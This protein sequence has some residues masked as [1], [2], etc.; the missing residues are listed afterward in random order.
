M[1]KTITI[2]RHLLFQFLPELVKQKKHIK[3]VSTESNTPTT[4]LACCHAQEG[5]T[6]SLVKKKQN[7]QCLPYVTLLCTVLVSMQ[8][9]NYIVIYYIIFIVFHY[10]YYV[11]FMPVLPIKLFMLLLV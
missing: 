8:V 6:F 7:K 5:M 4:T 3:V 1:L 2:Q 11:F 10:Y 9:A